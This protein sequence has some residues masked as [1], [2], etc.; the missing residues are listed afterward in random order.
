MAFLSQEFLA[1][2]RNKKPKNAGVLFDY[3]Y[4]RTYSR[5]IEEKQRRERWDETVERV[6]E[7]NVS[8][9]QGPAS[10]EEL[11]KEAELMYDLVFNLGVLPAGRQLWIGGTSAV[12]QFGEANFN[13][14]FAVIDELEI[15]GDI[16]HLLLC[17]C[18]VGFRVTK[19]AVDKLPWFNTNFELRNVE[20]S[21]AYRARGPEQTDVSITKHQTLPEKH[22]I[23][24][25][26]DSRE[27]WVKALR[28]FLDVLTNDDYQ[29]EIVITYD[30]VRSKGARLISFGGRA[31][32]PEGLRLMFDNISRI[33]QNS[34]GRLS[35]TD[36]VDICNFIGKNVLV[37]GMR[38]S[39]QIALG[40]PDDKSF[41]E[42]KKDM[43]I[44]K[45]NLHR[46][47]SNNSVVFEED[48]TDEQLM[49]IFAGLMNSGEPGF[50]NQKA[51]AKR[52]QNGKGTNP[53]G[54]ILLDSRGFC[55]L[56]TLNMMAFVNKRQEKGYIFD[57]RRAAEAIKLCVR[58]GLRTT[59]V[60][61]SLPKWDAVQKRDRLLG[62][63]RTGIM[64]CWDA[65]GVAFDSSEA[66]F[67]QRTLHLEA[68]Q[69][70]TRY[71]SEMRVPV[72]LLTT[73]IKP[74]GTLSQLP[75][76]SSGLH[77]AY[78]PHYIRRIRVSDIDPLCKAL[79]EAG[80]PNEPDENK[81]ERIVFSF[82]VKTEAKI[83]AIDEP[84]IRQY[85][86]YLGEMRYYVDH[87]ASITIMVG[88][89]EWIELMAE[90]K[91]NFKDTVAITCLPKIAE[92]K[93]PQLPYEAITMEQY[94]K[95]MV[96]F[97]DLTQIDIAALVNKYEKV[98]FE[99]DEALEAD[100]AGGAC[101]VR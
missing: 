8:L 93:Y 47:M 57:Q 16:F 96:G 61:I 37:G 74:E 28:T 63:S 20:P 58:I 65:M 100:C 82:P 24:Q 94:E 84:A 48:P 75:T 50:F 78:A 68:V 64:D 89:N 60:D 13:C 10:Y 22:V 25:V 72:P 42:L 12:T 40:S 44:L 69:E 33:I 26:G 98:Q 83:Y 52:R 51:V 5:W 30:R 101:P 76:V 49:N 87:N 14:S 97:P 32:G 62:V 7:Y 85:Q 77:R 39:S 41:I 18:G 66:Q 29:T 2:Y 4:L 45:Q 15:F 70:A 81:N 27:G 55:N 73:C 59:N 35:P 95:M 88:S 34:E 92:G 6:T 9:Y 71:A 17:G 43:W 31:P 67:I 19:E 38:R 90:V 3:V 36:C 23:I 99:E 56:S 86:R 54:E 53:C 80:V 91:K 11:V 46:D 79:Q 21:K 1:Q